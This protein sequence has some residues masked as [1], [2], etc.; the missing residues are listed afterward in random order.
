MKTHLSLL[1]LFTLIF[2]NSQQITD[3]DAL[4]NC[5]KEFNK[6]TCL[7]DK[8]E[9]GVLHYLDQCPYDA[10]PIENNGCPWPDTDGDFLIDKDDACPIVAGPLENNGCPWPDTDNDGIL[11]KDDA[12]P[13]VVGLKDNN[14]CPDPRIKCLE[15]TKSD[16]ISFKNFKLKNNNL[17]KNYEGLA[18]LIVQK[19]SEEKDFGLIYIELFET[20]PSCYYQPSGSVLQCRS[21]LKSNKY[22]FLISKLFS[23]YTFENLKNNVLLPITTSKFNLAS[24]EKMNNYLDMSKEQYIYFI[25]NYEGYKIQIKGSK[26][27]KSSKSL[28]LNASF[29][30][31]NPY[32]V[33]LDLNN[34]KYNYKF[35][36]NQWKLVITE[37]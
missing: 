30:E 27:N 28:K 35:V 20:E 9:D 12:C 18:D 10:G 11:D 31:E 8:D 6:K 5:R 37:K 4:K 1:F 25:K 29:V 24:E 13:T 16:S 33:I 14:G 26:T 15:I 22:D 3:K 19:I 23:K 36:N 17:S 32:D 7:S 2:C 34:K 21:T